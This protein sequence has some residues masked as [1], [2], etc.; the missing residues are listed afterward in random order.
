M[1]PRA[2]ALGTG[3]VLWHGGQNGGFENADVDPFV[4]VDLL[5]GD[6]RAGRTRMPYDA[7]AVRLA[8]GGGQA[9]SEARVRGR[10]LGEAL[11]NGGACSCR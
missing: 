4:E 11:R 3:G 6:L 10:L 8:F 1:V 5:Y 2:S 9:V 7:F